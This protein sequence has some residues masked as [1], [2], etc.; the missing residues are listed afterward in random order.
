MISIGMVFTDLVRVLLWL[1][2][3]GEPGWGAEFGTRWKNCRVLAHIA[4]EGKHLS[5]QYT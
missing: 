1:R 5:S 3:Q 4:G 2:C